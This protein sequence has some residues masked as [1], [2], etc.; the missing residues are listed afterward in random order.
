VA[1]LAQ[2]LGVPAFRLG[3]VGDYNGSFRL[4]IRDVILQYAVP[5]LREVYFTAIPRRMGD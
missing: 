2:E 1:A 4:Q 3:T 5:R